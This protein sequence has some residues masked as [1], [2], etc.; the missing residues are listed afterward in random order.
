MKHR[1]DEIPPWRACPF[2]SGERY[3]IVQ[4]VQSL[5][6]SFRIGEHLT[7]LRD[8]YSRFDQTTA[9]FFRDDRGTTRILDIADDVSENDWYAAFEPLTLGA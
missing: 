4:P 1:Q 5:R 6:D 8:A 7:F 2:A 9:Y 3:R